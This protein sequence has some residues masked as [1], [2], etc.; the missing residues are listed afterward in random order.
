MLDLGLAQQPGAGAGAILIANFLQ[1][2][3]SALPSFSVIV[4]SFQVGGF[5]ISGRI[6]HKLVITAI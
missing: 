2:Q 4:E 5:E 3:Y 6:N 1:L